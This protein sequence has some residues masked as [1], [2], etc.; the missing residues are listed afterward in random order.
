MFVRVAWESG[1][2]FSGGVV[3]LVS[4]VLGDGSSRVSELK[5]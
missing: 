3:E 2:D 4:G 1:V 5:F